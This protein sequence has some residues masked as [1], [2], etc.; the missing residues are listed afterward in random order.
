MKIRSLEI[1]N[2][3]IHVE[4]DNIQRPD[5]VYKEDKFRNGAELVAEIEKSIVFEER[6]KARKKEKTDKVKLDIDKI[7]EPLKDA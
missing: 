4:T 1:T 7:K 2:G 5:F 6:N 3:M